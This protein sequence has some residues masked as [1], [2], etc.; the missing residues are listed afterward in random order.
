METSIR[1]LTG[2]TSLDRREAPVRG[3]DLGRGSGNWEVPRLGG[4]DKP[5]RS[6]TC[7]GARR[8]QAE[9]NAEP[10][11]RHEVRRIGREPAQAGADD[12]APGSH[13]AEQSLDLVD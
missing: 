2:G 13:V 11:Q 12:G 8:L 3:A 1:L 6:S 4:G 5:P 7:L 10:L 9:R